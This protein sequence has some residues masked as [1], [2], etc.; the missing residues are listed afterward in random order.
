MSTKSTPFV[1]IRISTSGDSG[2]NR[3]VPSA[4]MPRNPL[5]SSAEVN[6]ACGFH[7][8][9]GFVSR[10]LPLLENH[11]VYSLSHIQ[12]DMAFLRFLDEIVQS[13]IKSRMFLLETEQLSCFIQKAMFREGFADQGSIRF[14]HFIPEL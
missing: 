10:T 7:S 11:F 14:P 13:L 8:G 1:E 5:F 12:K 3:R 9:N 2:K 6:S 4:K